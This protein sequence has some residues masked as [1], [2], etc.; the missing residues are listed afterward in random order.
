MVASVITQLTTVGKHFRGDKSRFSKIQRG[1][2]LL[3]AAKLGGQNYLQEAKLFMG[4]P[5]ASPPRKIPEHKK[6]H[7][8]IQL[9]LL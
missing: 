1:A 7:N 4:R 8:N 5:T 6:L 2:V 3:S 9:M